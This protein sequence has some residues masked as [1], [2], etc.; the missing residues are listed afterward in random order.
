MHPRKYFTSNYFINEILS[1]KKFQNYRNLYFAWVDQTEQQGYKSTVP[2]LPW[3]QYGH[4][5]GNKPLIQTCN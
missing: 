3:L 1:V 4:I 2:G 5:L